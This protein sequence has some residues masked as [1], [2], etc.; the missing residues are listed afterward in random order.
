M[1]FP[2][3]SSFRVLSDLAPHLSKVERLKK[4]PDEDGEKEVGAASTDVAQEE[5]TEQETVTP[6]PEAPTEEGTAPVPV[7]VP[8]GLLSRSG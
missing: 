2:V 3:N 5:N 7:P 8:D 1:D 6:A 4:K